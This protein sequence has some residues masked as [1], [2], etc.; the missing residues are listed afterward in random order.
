MVSRAVS[1]LMPLIVFSGST[2]TA[3]DARRF[4]EGR[5]IPDE[6]YCDQPYVVVTRDGSWLCTLTTGRG[7]EGDRG[8]HVVATISA[9]RGETWSALIDIEPA[10]GPEASWAVPLI[11]AGGRVYVFYDYNGDLVD[12][13]PGRPETIRA[14]MLGWYCYRYSDDG[15][16]TWS[17][18]RYR[19]PV[20]VTACDRANQWGGDVQ[21]L[22]GIDKP[23]VMGPM[24]VS[25]RP[26]DLGEFVVFAFTKLRRHLLEDGEGWL[27]RSRNILTEADPGKIVW[28][29]LPGGECGIR[30]EEYGSV[31]EEHNL[32]PLGGGRLYCVYRTGLGFPCHS[33]SEDGGRTWARPEPM[34]YAPGGRR[35]RNPRAC[36]KLWRTAGGKY[37][38]A[39]APP[40]SRFPRGPAP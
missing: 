9:D 26:E 38:A 24:L 15:G 35:I 23:K 34:T 29:M 25:T 7:R 20:R 21:V 39:R 3:G 19:L 36:P 30:A 12:R 13:F 1:I 16:R 32:L 40:A 31:Q 37:P 17:A 11:A 8:Q 22:W 4:E 5:S 14:D 6:G 2:G 18:Q 10:D 27:F 28:E 33:Y